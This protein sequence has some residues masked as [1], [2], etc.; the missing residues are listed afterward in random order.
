MLYIGLFS[1][2]SKGPFPFLIYPV[3]KYVK[4]K[5][6]KHVDLTKMETSQNDF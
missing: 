4:D 6:G 2:L 3:L 1:Y 5:A